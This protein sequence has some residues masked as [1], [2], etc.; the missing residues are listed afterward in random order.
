[1]CAPSIVNRPEKAAPPLA[2]LNPFCIRL[3][4][5]RP[6]FAPELSKTRLAVAMLTLASAAFS[7]SPGLAPVAQSRAAVRMDLECALS[8]N[9]RSLRGAS[10]G[11]QHH[12]AQQRSRRLRQPQGYQ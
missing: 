5:V 6:G 1:M 12:P 3:T 2:A 8:R 9:A 4:S 11:W 7:Y 10:R